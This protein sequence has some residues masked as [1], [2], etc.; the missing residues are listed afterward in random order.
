MKVEYKIVEAQGNIQVIEISNDDWLRIKPVD[1][2]EHSVELNEVLNNDQI[3]EGY[4]SAAFGVDYPL[5]ECS[6]GKVWI[7]NGLMP[8][9]VLEV[10]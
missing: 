4:A 9:E 8:I 2:E 10:A 1:D 6:E 7:F 5:D 3:P